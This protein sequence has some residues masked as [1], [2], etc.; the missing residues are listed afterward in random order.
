MRSVFFYLFLPAAWAFFT[1]C[2]KDDPADEIFQVAIPAD[3]PEVA[4]AG[5]ELAFEVEITAAAGLEKVETRLNFQPVD[6]TVQTGFEN[7][8]SGTYRFSFTPD[9]FDI[10]KNFDFVIAAYD[11]RGFTTTATYE[12][13][14]QEA[15]VNI[16]IL[17]PDAAPDTVDAGT[18]VSFDIQVVSEMELAEIGTL[19]QGSAIDSL[20]KTR[21]DDPFADQ[22][23]FSYTAADEDAGRELEFTIRVTDE[24][25]KTSEVTYPLFVLGER[26]P[27]PVII[28]TAE[29]GSQMSTGHGHFLDLADG[30]VHFREGVAAISAE[31][32]LALFYSSSTQGNLCAPDFGNAAQFIYTQANSGQDAL[33]L[34]PVRNSTELADVTASVT[35]AEFEAIEKD[36][37][38][39]GI[40][41]SAGATTNVLPAVAEDAIIAFLTADNKHGLIRVTKVPEN[42]AGS[43]VLEV[44]VQ[45]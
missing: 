42:N 28:Y 36:D 8:T 14:I 6:G 45:Q 17:V 18:H 23:R 37:M 10:G 7:A 12:V 25:E 9:R 35:E 21:F 38:L 1:A 5:R 26:E 33:G 34:W 15:P 44:K 20:T 41:E 11:R 24:E 13:A 43:M 2:E 30:S 29:V 4:Y 27:W 39:T 31:I 32:D 3:A 22:Y 16:S 19:L 40:F